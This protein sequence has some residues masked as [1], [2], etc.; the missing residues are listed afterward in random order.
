[1]LDEQLR[2]MHFCANDDAI[3]PAKG[4]ARRARQDGKHETRRG[5][6]KILG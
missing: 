5:D 6:S 1:M 3:K 4:I 2:R